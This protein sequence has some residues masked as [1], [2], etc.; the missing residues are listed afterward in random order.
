MNAKKR[1]I[2]LLCIL[3]YEVKLGYVHQLKERDNLFMPF[4]NQIISREAYIHKHNF[5]LGFMKEG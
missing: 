5:Y 4:C 1:L 3:N 2:S